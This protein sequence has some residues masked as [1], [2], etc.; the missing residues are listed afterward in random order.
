MSVSP[1]SVGPFDPWSVNLFVPVVDALK[2]IGAVINPYE[3]STVR[4]SLPGNPDQADLLNGAE[5]LLKK[6]Y[7]RP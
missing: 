5:R 2:L 7:R 6:T 4:L 3:L 1:V